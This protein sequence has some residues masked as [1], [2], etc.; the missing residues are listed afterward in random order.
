MARINTNTPPL[1]EKFYRVS[2]TVD[3]RVFLAL[4]TSAFRAVQSVALQLF[5]PARLQGM[6]IKGGE[7]TAE[8]RITIEGTLHLVS[9]RPFLS[10]P[11]PASSAPNRLAA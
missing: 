7:S 11:T 3:Q 10:V 6:S 2:S 4:S 9:A 8:M 5:G 1:R